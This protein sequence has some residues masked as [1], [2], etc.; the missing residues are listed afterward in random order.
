[1]PAAQSAIAPAT[2]IFSR[3]TAQRA[4]KLLVVD[5]RNAVETLCEIL[6]DVGH[7]CVAAPK[8]R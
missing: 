4:M 6:C 2:I 5:G 7:Q 1:M 3:A 8:R